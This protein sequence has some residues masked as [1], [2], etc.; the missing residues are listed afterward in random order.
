MSNAICSGSGVLQQTLHPELSVSRTC[1]VLRDF[2]RSFCPSARPLSEVGFPFVSVNAHST[3]RHSVTFHSCAFTSTQPRFIFVAAQVEEPHPVS[4]CSRMKWL[5]LENPGTC[6]P[7][8]SFLHSANSAALLL[9]MWLHVSVLLWHTSP[10][11][12]GL[13]FLMTLLCFPKQTW[14]LEPLFPSHFIH[15]NQCFLKT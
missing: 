11:A 12:P 8:L 2:M 14:F 13:F 10:A 9:Q 15:L 7:H 1:F 5:Q 4:G 6:S 3:D